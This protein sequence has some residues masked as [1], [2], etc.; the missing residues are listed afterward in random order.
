MA[1]P[2]P[3]LPEVAVVYRYFRLRSQAPEGKRSL[4]DKAREELARNERVINGR[5]ADPSLIIVD[6]RS[7][8]TTSLAAEKGFDAGK[9]YPGLRFISEWTSLGLRTT[10]LRPALT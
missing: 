3:L 9:K 7:I 5:E 1:F 8:K 10:F 4:L 2:A 6:A